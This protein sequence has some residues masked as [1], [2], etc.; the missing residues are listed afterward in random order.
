MSSLKE[1]DFWLTLLSHGG[2]LINDVVVYTVN[3]SHIGALPVYGWYPQS[4]I[5]TLLL[6]RGAILT[7]IY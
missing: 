2:S 6:V 5:K 3:D 1:E 4:L 7:N